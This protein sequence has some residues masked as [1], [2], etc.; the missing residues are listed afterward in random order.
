MFPNTSAR[1]TLVSV[2]QYGPTNRSLFSTLRSV[3]QVLIFIFITLFFSFSSDC[4]TR[5]VLIER[6][7]TS[8]YPLASAQ[9]AVTL[10]MVVYTTE[11][12]RK[13]GTLT[14]NA[15][16]CLFF[17]A[18]FATFLEFKINTPAF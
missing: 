15:L 18:N 8:F 5:S 6:E 11:K 1:F 14:P 4:E 16:F 9:A 13:D 7:V 12:S 2:V 3:D 10:K 17:H